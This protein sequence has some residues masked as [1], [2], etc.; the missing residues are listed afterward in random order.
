MN[1]T[2][3]PKALIIDDQPDVAEILAF[4]MEEHFD[5]TIC[6]D[7][8]EALKRVSEENWDLI[9]SDLVMPQCS[10]KDLIAARPDQTKP[11][12]IVSGKSDTD[13]EVVSLLKAGASLFVRKPIMSSQEFIAK[14][15]A[16]M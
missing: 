13:P 3:K 8:S 11:F 4:Y 2:S 12:V 15:M 14:L 10:A 7:G 6:S 5:S 1:S 16:L 9:I